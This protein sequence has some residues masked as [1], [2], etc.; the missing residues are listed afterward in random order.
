ME[1]QPSAQNPQPISVELE[2]VPEDE[3]DADPAAVGDV[4]RRVVAALQKDG[5]N[6]RPVYTGARGDFLFILPLLTFVGQAIAANKDLLVE[7]L[8]SVQPVIEYLFKEREMQASPDNTQ[9][10]VKVAVEIDGASVSV[11]APDVAS[12]E[13]L[14]NLANQFRTAHPTVAENIKLQSKV[15][16]KGR[17]PK[18]QIRRRR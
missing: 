9:G 15:K 17:V 8:K 1:L 6:V 2:F 5:Y 18:R 7:L 4:G 13:S 14:I 16:V 11:E 3:Q 10:Y 12:S